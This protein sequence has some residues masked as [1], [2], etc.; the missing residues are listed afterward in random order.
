MNLLR[1]LKIYEDSSKYKKSMQFTKVY[2]IKNV[3]K[4][5]VLI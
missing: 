1:P 3:G 2:A 4:E 5:V